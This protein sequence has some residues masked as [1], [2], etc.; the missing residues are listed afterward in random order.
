MTLSPT[1]VLIVCGDL[2]FSTQLRSSGERAGAQIELELQG[3][4]A[5]RRA[6]SI[7]YDVMIVDLET[8]GLDVGS[9]M[10]SLGEGERP[11]VI[12]FGPHV[13]EQRLAAARTAGCDLVV[14]RGQI[15]TSLPALVLRPRASADASPQSD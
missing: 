6:A 7:R 9:L 11:R 5:A 14:S 2:F 3:S 8:P 4:Q 13:Q 10:E 12:A 1:R 15:A